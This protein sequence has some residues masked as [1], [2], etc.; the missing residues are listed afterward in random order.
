MKVTFRRTSTAARKQLPERGSRVCQDVS[1]AFFSLCRSITKRVSTNA[2]LYR[3]VL[4]CYNVK[5]IARRNSSVIR[6]GRFAGA[7]E[8]ASREFHKSTGMCPRV[9]RIHNHFRCR[10]RA[11]PERDR[12]ACNSTAVKEFSRVRVSSNP[13]KV[14]VEQE[15]GAHRSFNHGL[16]GVSL[17]VSLPNAGKRIY[18]ASNGSESYRE[19]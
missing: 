15:D 13:A 1:T 18:S 12:L 7:R 10:V 16:I 2:G 4:E 14:E 6:S 3:L 19:R 9:M 5:K 11:G 8:G 17:L